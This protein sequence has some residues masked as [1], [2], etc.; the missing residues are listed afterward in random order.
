MAGSGPLDFELDNTTL[1]VILLVVGFLFLLF[2][3]RDGRALG[4]N[5]RPDL[6]TYN[7][8]PILGNTLDMFRNRDKV[9]ESKQPRRS[10]GPM[11]VRAEPHIRPDLHRFCMQ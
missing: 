6:L 2:K 5:P 11:T 7:G 10:G 3:Y 9:L 1:G 8:L 4:T